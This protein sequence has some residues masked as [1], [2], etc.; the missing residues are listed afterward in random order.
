[1]QTVNE[2]Y[3]FYV[4]R[5]GLQ[6]LDFKVEN[7]TK[8]SKR[9]KNENRVAR[10]SASTGMLTDIFSRMAPQRKIKNSKTA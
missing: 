1:M 8:E 2:N 5:S 4:K 7:N 3:N 6:K 9:V 10:I